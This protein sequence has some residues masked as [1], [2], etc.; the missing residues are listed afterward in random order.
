[1]NRVITI[2]G[3]RNTTT[4]DL[5]TILGAIEGLVCDPSVSAIY[6][7]GARGA[8]TI[9]LNA[10][11]SIKEAIGRDDINLVCIVPD[12]VDKQPVETREVSKQ[13]DKLI[14]L[15]NTI[16]TSDGY[17]SYH[18]RNH[19]M[20]NSSTEVV[21]FWNGDIRSGTWSTIKYAKA[22]KKPVTIVKIEGSD[23]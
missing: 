7:G 16:T 21:A 14:E 9:A 8:D 6:F 20:V 11:L 15:G 17:S 5:H 1:M 19:Y 18:A 2:T 3:N 10:A 4:N 13:A 23:K 22:I 12:T